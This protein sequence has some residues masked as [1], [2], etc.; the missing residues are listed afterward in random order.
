MP[1]TIIIGS[2]SYLPN[3]V[4]GR[5]FF[6]DSEFY[7]DEGVKIDKPVEETI[8]KF[9]EITEIEN[10]R[11]IDE[12]LSNSQIGFEAAKIAIADANVDQEELDY[13]IYASNFGEVTVN[14]YVDFM[15]TMA[16]RVKNKL[17]I[18][19]RKCITY[20]MIFGCP[21][22]VEAMILADNLIKAKVAKTILV[23]GAETLSRVTDPYDRNRMIF[24]DGAGAVVVQATDEED[25]GIIAHNTICDNGPEL[26]YLANGPS[27]NEASDQTRLFVRMQGRKIYEYALKNVPGAIKETIEDAKLSIEDI[28][29]ILIHQANAKMD[30]A[31]IDRLHKLYDV[32]DYDH[33]VSPMTVQDLGNTSV[34]T[35]PTMFDLIIKGKMEGHTFKDK[36]NIVMTSVG[37]GMN[38]NA[39][40]YK[41]P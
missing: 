39:I 8:A 19:N 41:F 1:N 20:D 27:I 4:I 40:V 12:D 38:I 3:R 22:W 11:F 14:G 21:G 7:T 24:A 9:V 37:A 25:V 2:G 26:N 28:D 13:I 31:M 15:P 17:G 35:I 10:R 34:A 23:I 36:G 5:D 32:K 16:A 6:L 18:K 33:S 29:K 30:Y